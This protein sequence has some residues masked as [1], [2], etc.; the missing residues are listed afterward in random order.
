M[1]LGIISLTSRQVGRILAEIHSPFTCGYRESLNP[2]SLSYVAAPSIQVTAANCQNRYPSP[3]TRSGP[4][5]ARPQIFSG[6]GC[7]DNPFTTSKSNTFGVTAPFI[8]PCG[9]KGNSDVH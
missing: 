1:I 8:P 6:G 9:A 4:F 7:S 2:I 5:P 3:S